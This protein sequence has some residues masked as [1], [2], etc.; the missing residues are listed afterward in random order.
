MNEELCREV[1]DYPAE[2]NYANS[3]VRQT[4][5][6]NIDEYRFLFRPQDKK[7]YQ[8]QDWPTEIVE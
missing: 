7:L 3:R 1:L 2:V 8:L 6:M 5:L 4:D